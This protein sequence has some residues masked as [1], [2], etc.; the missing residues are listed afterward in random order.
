MLLRS[1]REQQEISEARIQVVVKSNDLIRSSRYKLNLYEQKILLFLI[2]KIKPDDEDFHWYAFSLRDMCQLMGISTNPKNYKNFRDSIQRLSDKSFWI[3]TE[4][5]EMLCRWILDVRITNR[6][7]IVKI[8]LDDKLKPYLLQLQKQFTEFPL[9]YILL[10]QNK[11]SIRI[12]ELLKSYAYQG[13]YMT[14]LDEFKM[15]IQSAAYKTYRDFR[16]N[17]LDPA[18]DEINKYTDLNV[19][20]YP[21]REGRSIQILEFEIAEKSYNDLDNARKQRDHEF[22]R[23][24]RAEIIK[25]M[26]RNL[27]S[28]P[29]E[30][31]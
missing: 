3:K 12:Y 29:Y 14:R 15:H 17:I 6:Q 22:A 13:V 31:I 16:V 26:N 4:N 1:E 30:S 25:K 11:Y 8:R 9:E 19:E 2:S 10:M 23:A 7:S 27:L 24:D 18:M 21:I 20:V 5:E 28:V